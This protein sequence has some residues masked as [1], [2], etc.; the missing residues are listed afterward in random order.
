[1]NDP[2]LERVTYQIPLECEMFV[3]VPPAIDAGTLLCIALHGYGSNAQTMLRLTLP[4]L[5]TR[6][7]VAALQAP[8]QH[9][10]Q[11]PGPDAAAAYNWGIRQHWEHAVRT[12]HSMLL[13]AAA[14]LGSQYGIGPDR[15]L[16]IGF[17]QPVGLN[18]R[19]IGTHT[20]VF[21]GVIGM[22]GGVPR[23]WEERNYQPIEAA[24][25]HISRDEDEY[26]PVP[27]VLEFPDR[28]KRYASDVEFH[29]IPGKHRFPSKA[30]D[31]VQPWLR[32]VFRLD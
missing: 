20:G 14:R 10:V 8:N 31:I 25:L 32:R 6:H 16:L 28:L 7:L 23:D 29:L 2:E 18:Y 4:V 15:S 21:R 11:Q 3:H 1:M 26:Y 12:H 19:F 13:Q 5:G 30:V 17:S 22:C 9:Y 27:K 24:L